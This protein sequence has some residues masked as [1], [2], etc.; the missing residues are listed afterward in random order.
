MIFIQFLLYIAIRQKLKKIFWTSKNLGTM[1]SSILS[2]LRL[3]FTLS[4]HK[5]TLDK[6][7]WREKGG[8]SAENGTL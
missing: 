3:F 5:P 1:E 4:V 2:F 7:F 6:A 8:V